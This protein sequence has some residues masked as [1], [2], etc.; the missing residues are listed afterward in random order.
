LRHVFLRIGNEHIE[1]LLIGKMPVPTEPSG[2]EL[3][4]SLYRLAH[5]E[6]CDRVVPEDHEVVRT[7]ILIVVGMRSQTKNQ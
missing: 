4:G 3:F 7:G 2:V 6:I 5:S 1:M